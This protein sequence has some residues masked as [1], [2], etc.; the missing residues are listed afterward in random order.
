[1]ALL[2][3]APAAALAAEV[4]PDDIYPGW[5]QVTC[6]LAYYV[7][8]HYNGETNGLI[9]DLR[10][11]V[12][13]QHRTNTTGIEA[14]GVVMQVVTPKEHAGQ[15]IC[16]RLDPPAA[17]SGGLRFKPGLVYAGKWRREFIGT[18]TFKGEVPFVPVAPNGAANR[19]QP[20]RSETNRTSGAAGS[21]R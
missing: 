11:D 12:P 18:L 13:D 20:D 5:I 2:F 3:L 21:A 15:T 1:M 6:K 16:I 9:Y 19:S 4:T 14:E 10:L 7:E 8:F 17:L